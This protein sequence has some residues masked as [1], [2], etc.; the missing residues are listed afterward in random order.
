MNIIEVNSSDREQINQLLQRNTL[1]QLD[2]NSSKLNT[3]I[4]SDGRQF[5]L[6]WKLIDSK[7]I[8]RGIVLNLISEY[9]HENKIYYASIISTWAVDK[10]YRKDTGKL[11]EKFL[12]Q[13]NVDFLING[14]AIKPIARRL[15]NAKFLEVKNSDFKKVYF[16]VTNYKNFFIFLK[17]KYKLPLLLSYILIKSG[18]LFD[19][20]IKLLFNYKSNSNIKILNHI[21]DTFDKDFKILS[22]KFSILKDKKNIER[23]IKNGLRNNECVI[24]Y[25]VV[26]A[27]AVGYAIVDIFNFKENINKMTIFDIH[28]MDNNHLFIKDLLNE[29]ICYGKNQ[30][31]AFIEIY[32]TQNDIKKSIIKTR[33]FRRSFETNPFYF[34][35]MNDEL[36]NIDKFKLWMPT[37]FDT[38]RSFY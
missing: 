3:R 2:S 22:N 35:V 26:N 33:P 36:N 28:V 32:G 7:K 13:K 6:G 1:S 9:T 29:I 19:K 27:T 5:P 14:S 31:Y 25:L 23:R 37:I 20:F 17:F 10:D 4:F 24:F 30:D 11:L 12:M 15:I 34:R 8:I 18:N 16:W 21:P 38:D